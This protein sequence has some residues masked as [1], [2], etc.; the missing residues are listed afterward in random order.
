MSQDAAFPID[1]ARARQEAEAFRSLQRAFNLFY[2]RVSLTPAPEWTE[3]D[4]R[5]LAWF[6]GAA[7]GRKLSAILTNEIAAANERAALSKGSAFDCGWAC[8][9]RGLLAW[10]QALAAPSAGGALHHP[11]HH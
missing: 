1:Q 9:Y 10:L 2:G 4:A 7:T 8:G 3:E 11:D 6:L 5:H